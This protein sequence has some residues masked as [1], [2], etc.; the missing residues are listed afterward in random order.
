M[1]LPTVSPHYSAPA[2]ALH[3]LLALAILGSMG[4]AGT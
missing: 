3:W 4:L 1:S 2:I